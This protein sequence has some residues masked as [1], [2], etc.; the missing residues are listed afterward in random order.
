MRLSKQ[1]VKEP[2]KLL[3]EPIN[4]GGGGGTLKGGV[5]GMERLEGLVLAYL[6]G[7]KANSRG[8]KQGKK[9]GMQATARKYDKHVI[10]GSN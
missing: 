1:K 6:R 10:G 4:T 3:G 9:G 2:Q 8:R 7:I 5:S